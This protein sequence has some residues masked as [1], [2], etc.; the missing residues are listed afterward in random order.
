MSRNT[1]LKYG[2]GVIK[3]VVDDNLTRVENVLKEH[4]AIRQ[5]AVTYQQNGQGEDCLVAYL[6]GDL[7]VDR[8]PLKSECWCEDDQGKRVKLGIADISH[9]G[10]CLLNTPQAW[11]I[12][13]TINL[14]L[15]FPGMIHPLRISTK[16][17][18]HQRQ[19]PSWLDALGEWSFGSGRKSNQSV[20]KSFALRNRTGVLF[21]TTP[22]TLKF[23]QSKIK[24][25][26]NQSGVSVQDLRNSEPRIPLHTNV[27]VCFA[28]GRSF[29]WETENISLTGMRIQGVDGIWKKGTELQ[30]VL[31]LPGSTVKLNLRATVWW[32]KG[33][34]AGLCLHLTPEEE[35]V[36]HEGIQYIIFTQGLSLSNLHYLLATKLTPELIPH[37]F[38]MLEEM[39][40]DI[41]GR[42][43]L[44]TLPKPDFLT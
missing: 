40:F 35:A 9:N 11:S 4:P 1:E 8:I 15:D 22:E 24:E 6:V 29:G 25:L 31:R 3:P 34:Q 37:N 14:Y 30:L 13:K 7:A 19:Q 21:T 44:S 27:R 28:D 42:V 5:V 36:I 32:H 2:G 18:W 43:D 23:I 16:V 12:G 33:S 20:G 41:H 38:V 39:P 17:V 26:S 10:V